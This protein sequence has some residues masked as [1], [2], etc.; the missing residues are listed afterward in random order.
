MAAIGSLVDLSQMNWRNKPLVVKKAIE[1]VESNRNLGKEPLGLAWERLPDHRPSKVNITIKGVEREQ[2]EY[3]PPESWDAQLTLACW[4]YSIRGYVPLDGRANIFCTK[5]RS[6]GDVQD[7]ISTKHPKSKL[8]A[9]YDTILS[10][11]DLIDEYKSE[12]LS[13]KELPDELTPIQKELIERSV[14]GAVP[15]SVVESIKRSHGIGDIELYNQ[16]QTMKFISGI[17]L[18]IIPTEIRFQNFSIQEVV[19]M[20]KS[21]GLAPTLQR[22]IDELLEDLIEQRKKLERMKNRSLWERIINREY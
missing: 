22:E 17:D 1:W 18:S 6:R 19:E 5:S 11:Q 3:D 12:V 21:E 20:L 9:E 13:Q 4:L 14:N 7:S 16:W 15:G 2:G 10:N 8:Q